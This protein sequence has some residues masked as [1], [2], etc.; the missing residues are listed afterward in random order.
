MGK[1][2]SRRR[3]YVITSVCARGD[4]CVGGKTCSVL[5][6]ERPALRRRGRLGSLCLPVAIEGG[7]VSRSLGLY[8]PYCEVQSPGVRHQKNGT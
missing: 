1:V 6:G 8:F 7:C 3:T 2:G 5:R 4:S